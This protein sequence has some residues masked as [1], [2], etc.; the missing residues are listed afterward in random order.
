MPKYKTL[1]CLRGGL[2]NQLFQY[3]YAVSVTDSASEIIFESDLCLPNAN[4]QGK[5]ELFDLLHFTEVVPESKVHSWTLSKLLNLTLRKKAKGETPKYLQII[6]LLTSICLFLRFKKWFLINSGE[7]VGYTP[8]SKKRTYTL[9]NGYFQSYRWVSIEKLKPLLRS[10]DT[11][12]P[13]L[14]GYLKEASEKKV[15]A[16]HVRMGDYALFEEFGVLPKDYYEKALER[17]KEIENFEVIW[18]FS[19]D[20]QRGPEMIPDK[21]S[22][23]V[24]CI[25]EDLTSVE[26]LQVMR[27]ANSY[28]IGNSTF[29]WWGAMLSNTVSATV[30]SPI[31]WFQKMKEPIDL[32]PPNW[33]RISTWKR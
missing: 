15:L 14:K 32:I 26:T 31:P 9:V 5:P 7:G 20:L 17:M 27:L 2:G 28:I 11:N 21:Y 3:A 10:I 1:V 24:R 13:R 29:S 33:E 16:V 30:I 18:L 12:D 6:E 8:I 22:N 23:L 25:S 19:N 4:L